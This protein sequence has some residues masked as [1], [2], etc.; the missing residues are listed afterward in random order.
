MSVPNPPTVNELPLSS[1]GTL[2]FQ[3]YAPA[4][5]PTVDSYTLNYVDASGNTG[6]ISGITGT[7]RLV[8]G[9]VNGRT[10]TFD[11]QAVNGAGSS[12][13][14]Y[15]IPFQPG[16]GAPT[17]VT[18]ATATISGANGVTIT[19]S[20]ATTPDATIFWYVIRGISNSPGDPEIARTAGGSTSSLS[21]DGLNINSTYTFTVEA[22]NC[23]GYSPAFFTNSISFSSWTY[24]RKWPIGLN[25][26]QFSEVAMSSNGQYVVG[27]VYGGKIWTSSNYGNTWIEQTTSPTKNWYGVACSDDGT[28]V[29]AVD[30]YDAA[31]PTTGK[32]WKSTDSG[33]TFT[34]IYPSLGS[35]SWGSIH[36]IVCSSDGQFIL[37]YG[38]NY[39]FFGYNYGGT[40]VQQNGAGNRNWYGV[41]LSDDGS[42]AVA[43]VYSGSIWTGAINVASGVGTWTE[44]LSDTPRDWTCIAGSSDGVYL[45][46]GIYLNYMWVSRDSGVNWT[47]QGASLANP[48]PQY[49]WAGV[50]ISD[51]GSSIAAVENDSGQKI[52]LATYSSGVD[53]DWSEATNSIANTY[54]TIRGS[55]TLANMIAN[56]QGQ[57]VYV[58][59]DSGVNWINTAGNN[60][61]STIA[62]SSNN[63]NLLA[64]NATDYV[65]QSTDG[66]NT[67]TPIITLGIKD[68][69]S[70]K[71]STNGTRLAT[72][73]SVYSVGGYLS[74]SINSGTNWNQVSGVGT[75]D[76]Q[77][78][79]SLT[80]SDDG[81]IIYLTS[82]SDLANPGGPGFVWKGIDSG[83][84]YVWTSLSLPNSGSFNPNGISVSGDGSIV[85]LTGDNNSV[86]DYL[87]ISTNGGST[88]TPQ[89]S[90]GTGFWSQSATNTTGT[91]I[92]VLGYDGT[93][94][95]VYQGVDS[96]SGYVWTQRFSSPSITYTGPAV[97]PD[98]T[99][100]AVGTYSDYLYISNDSGASF[101]AQNSLVADNYNSQQLTDSTHIF[102]AT[103]SQSIQAGVYA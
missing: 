61:F 100:L 90:L 10:Y 24:T 26:A 97:S 12:D 48:S 72:I 32:L 58:T 38:G 60:S 62:S 65:Y 56:T 86:V 15:F 53:Y 49:G 76:L 18:A 40:F 45:V 55:S 34:S 89:S 47:E 35:I 6:S 78:W 13:P 82:Y 20:G 44:R 14:V 52:S 92:L 7:Y 99:V 28:I 11:V 74:I 23:P 85:I 75:P 57:A 37:A 29:Y 31:D 71:S 94:S 22:V 17:A 87:F 25:G 36:P 63:T 39:I 96:G 81:T 8:S 66:G 51:D 3:W 77:E 43:I 67:W 95:I 42:K 83:S 80:I 41:T 91:T 88:W 64:A 70:V 98:G 59:S 54:L 2:E 9:L 73:Y 19:W 93:N 27:C 16:T 5:G 102:S 68:W 30:D 46:A 69:I 50:T 101:Q 33:A 1:N 84:G 103:Y 21:I 79:N 4:S